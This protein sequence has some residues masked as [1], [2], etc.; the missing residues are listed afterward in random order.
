MLQGRATDL[1][2]NISWTSPWT[3]YVDRTGPS[4]PTDVG[5]DDWDASTGA[6]NV[7]WEPGADPNLAGG[8]PGSGYDH[9]GVRYKLPGAADYTDWIIRDDDLP[10]R[11]VSPG[12]TVSVQLRSVDVSDNP[13]TTLTFSFTVADLDPMPL[14]VVDYDVDDNGNQLSATGNRVAAAA[15]PF[16]CVAGRSQLK[17]A[18]T[19]FSDSKVTETDVIVHGYGFMTCDDP[20]GALGVAQMK[21]KT[22]V[23]FDEGG[24]T[25]TITC[26]TNTK[27]FTRGPVLGTVKTPVDTLCRAG[28][29]TYDVR[30]TVQL[31]YFVPEIGR[32][33]FGRKMSW[34]TPNADLPCNNGGAWR[35]KATHYL[36]FHSIDEVSQISSPSTL[37][38]Q[39]LGAAPTSTGWAA[40]HMIA[41]NYKARASAS[42]PLGYICG[43]G[44]NDAENG[45]WLRG[46]GLRPTDAAYRLLSDDEQKTAYHP[47]IHT[48]VYFAAVA[49][50]LRPLVNG[51]SCSRTAARVEL[52]AIKQELLRNAFPYLPGTPAPDDP[53]D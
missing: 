17:P 1:A 51:S 10:I 52:Q 14:E 40:H 3:I 38:G 8:A 7:S 36:S 23:R 41:A 9:T 53:N 21:V 47:G 39:R 42:Q 48:D 2:G 43:I 15:R 5:Q 35:F 44:P 46:P 24:D 11:G 22:C 19:P 16:P 30:V 45:V 26:K 25:T 27:D 49:A 31:R 50:R 34:S 33:P 12:Q 32:K 37:L 28:T 18:L 4:A 6:M 20:R 29:R 13:G